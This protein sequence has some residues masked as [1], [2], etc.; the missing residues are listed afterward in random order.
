MNLVEI[1]RKLALDQP[2]SPGQQRILE[3]ERRKQTNISV[4]K[5]QAEARTRLK[6]TIEIAEGS[7]I[8]QEEQS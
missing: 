6:G 5:A 1:N 8:G 3:E 4:A 7:L 2:L